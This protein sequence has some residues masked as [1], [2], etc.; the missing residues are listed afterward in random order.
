[1]K[2]DKKRFFDG[3]SLFAFLE[4]PLESVLKKILFCDI[5]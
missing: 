4:I 3:E 5:M 2:Y 1:M